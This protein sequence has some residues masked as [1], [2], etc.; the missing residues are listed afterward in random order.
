MHIPIKTLNSGG[1]NHL[2][3]S[4]YRSYTRIPQSK[5]MHIMPRRH[6]QADPSTSSYFVTLSLEYSMLSGKV[7]NEA[8][9][10]GG[11]SVLP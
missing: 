1:V 7:S 8:P 5:S 2:P 4:M 6:I 11:G 10:G 3:S 9:R